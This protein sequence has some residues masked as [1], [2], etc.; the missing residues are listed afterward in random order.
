[1]G[2]PIAALTCTDVESIPVGAPTALQI[3]GGWSRFVVSR[4]LSPPPAPLSSLGW[5]SYQRQ[6][7]TSGGVAAPSVHSPCRDPGP[8]ATMLPAVDPRQITICKVCNFAQSL[9]SRS[10]EPSMIGVFATSEVVGIAQ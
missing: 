3:S 7:P 2:A 8:S 4:V 6:P 1:M 10:K 5:V 9:L